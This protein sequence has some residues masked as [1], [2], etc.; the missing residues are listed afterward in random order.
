MLTLSGDGADAEGMDC[1]ADGKDFEGRGRW[2]YED[3]EVE[4][5]ERIV[6][7]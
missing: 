6:N 1:L 7:V 5:C 4:R 3:E 2:P